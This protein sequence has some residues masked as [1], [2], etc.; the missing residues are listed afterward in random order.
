MT[1]L[2]YIAR[3][4]DQAQG[5]AYGLDA[6]DRIKAALND[7]QINTYDPALAFATSG[8]PG[9]LIADLNRHILSRAN[10][11]VA[12][13]PP[14][15]AT[16]GVPIE[17]DR[18]IAVGKPTLIV[19]GETSWA[20]A[21]YQSYP[22]VLRINL[23][24]D[25]A[26]GLNW[27]VKQLDQPTPGRE[28]LPFASLREPG[29]REATGKLPKRVYQGDTGYDLV[30]SQTVDVSPGPMVDVPCNLAVELPPHLWG[31]IVGRSSTLRS[32]RLVVHP[33]VID[34]GYRGELFAAVSTLGPD[35]VRVQMGDRLAQLIP[36]TN[37]APWL[38]PV[39]VDQLGGSDRGV[40]GF[41]SSGL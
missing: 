7:E 18:A 2:I 36:M 1:K 12:L 8:Q 22:H 37:H 41:G 5:Y 20:L 30:V 27:L 24:N 16:I 34:S 35:R 13:L 32:K 26:D 31:L 15:V 40:R 17:I 33:G 23:N 19:G 10:A 39:L 38:E 29:P 4:I 25:I 21:E 9:P 14:G 11:I 3:P 6:A 28:P